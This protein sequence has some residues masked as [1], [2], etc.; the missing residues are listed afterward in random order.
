MLLVHL[1]LARPV[2]ELFAF[3]KV[4]IPAGSTRTVKVQKAV[5]TFGFYNNRGEYCLGDGRFKI[6]A[7]KSSADVL[8]TEVYI[9][10]EEA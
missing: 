10:F 6:F 5:D 7:G 1:S 3:E 4:H 8:E 2:K 9:K